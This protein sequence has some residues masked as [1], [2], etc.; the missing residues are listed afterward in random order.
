MPLV[1]ELKNIMKIEKPF[2]VFPDLQL[3]FSG[4]KF[5]VFETAQVYISEI[6]WQYSVH[7]LQK[8]I[9]PAIQR[10]C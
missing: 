2:G 1:K 10:K 4:W 5:V 3:I 8:F 7:V 9:R 6:A